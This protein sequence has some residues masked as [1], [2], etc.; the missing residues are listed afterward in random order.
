MK[1]KEKVEAE[2]IIQESTE[3]IKDLEMKLSEA[4]VQIEKTVELDEQIIQEST[5]KIRDL[6]MKLSEANVKIEKTVEL[7]MELTKS[8]VEI[9][10]LQDEKKE[11]SE[12]LNVTVTNKKEL[13]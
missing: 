2:Q 5:E 6:E 10:K 1:L 11:L 8:R 4:N 13:E 9:Q 3:K 12:T 7:D